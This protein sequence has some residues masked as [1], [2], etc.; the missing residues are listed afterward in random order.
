MGRQLEQYDK[1][2]GKIRPALK[3][4]HRPIHSTKQASEEVAEALGKGNYYGRCLRDSASHLLRTGG[5]IPFEEGGFAG[6]VCI[7][8]LGFQAKAK[9]SFIVSYVKSN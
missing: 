8:R 3:A 4:K 5:Q 1:A 7:V 9:W 2:P 6:Q